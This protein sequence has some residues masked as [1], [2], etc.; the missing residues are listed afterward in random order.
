MGALAIFAPARRLLRYALDSRA[1]DTAAAT[2]RSL[3]HRKPLTIV[4]RETYAQVPLCKSPRAD[5][6]AT[7]IRKIMTDKPRGNMYAGRCTR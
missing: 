7:V 5:K 1:A 3:M 4:K 6:T 2:P